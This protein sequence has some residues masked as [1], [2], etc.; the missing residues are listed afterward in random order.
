MWAFTTAN[1]LSSLNILF[2]YCFRTQS[3]QV[4]ALSIVSAVVKVLELMMKRVSSTFK[5]STARE[6]SIGSTLAK[7]LSLLPW[8][9]SF[10][11]LLD[12]RAS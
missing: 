9:L 2:S 10:K 7:N 5:P 4:L 11:S 6:K 8:I 1:L 12:R 3:L